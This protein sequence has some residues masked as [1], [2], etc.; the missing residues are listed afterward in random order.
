MAQ[1]VCTTA[2]L[3][4]LSLGLVSSNQENCTYF[5]LSPI[6]CYYME[7]TFIRD[8]SFEYQ[9][10]QTNSF[11]NNT[12]NYNVIEN[13]YDSSDCSGD[14]YESYIYDCNS[15]YCNCDGSID[16]CSILTW[17]ISSC[18]DTIEYDIQ[19]LYIPNLCI[20]TNNG[21]YYQAYDNCVDSEGPLKLKYYDDNQCETKSDIQP[22][23]ES[24][25]YACDYESCSYR[26]ESCQAGSANSL[27]I[28]AVVAIVAIVIMEQIIM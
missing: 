5:Q 1:R 18:Y 3:V 17:S 15:D 22:D 26:V 19:Y 20:T 9:C 25:C 11:N 27:K 12:S 14:V 16:D 23:S 10:Q 13:Y 24:Y 4:I 2:L 28:F 6:G 8:E 21:E 7:S